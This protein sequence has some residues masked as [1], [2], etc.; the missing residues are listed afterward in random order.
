VH[1]IVLTQ[2]EVEVLEQYIKTSPLQTVRFRAHALLMRDRQLGIEKIAQLTFCSVRTVTRWLKEFVEKR[3]SSLFSGNVENENA[4]KL[5]REQKEEIKKVL[6]Q[7]P[8]EYGIPKEF[9]DVPK[10]KEYVHVVF[11]VEYESEQSYHFLLKFSGFSFKY[12]DKVS[13]RRDE[14]SIQQRILEVREEI[15]PLLTNENWVVFAS[16]ET[17]VQLEAEIR[18]AWLIKGKRTAVKTERTSEHQNYLGFLD[19][20]YGTCQ[21]FEIER[22]NQQ[23]TISVLKKLLKQYPDK[24]ICIVW[25]NAK[26]HRGKKVRALLGGGNRFERIHLINL[27]TYAPEYNPIEHVW[28]YGKEKI[29]NR[30][31]QL[32]EEIKQSFVEAI[33]QRTFAYQI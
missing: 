3:I 7:P 24:R 20:K 4:G 19:Q 31:N 1:V 22:G 27:P 8:N 2:P 26:W 28:N 10:L 11:G 15:A 17:R 30:S 6:S 29:K 9:W 5:N 33:T 23:E 12:P 13:P 18:R 14:A 32:F 16:D 25:D 21:V